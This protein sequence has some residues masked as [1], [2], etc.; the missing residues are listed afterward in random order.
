MSNQ[1]KKKNE[2]LPF[3][4]PSTSYIY[5]DAESSIGKSSSPTVASLIDDDASDLK[6]NTI[7]QSSSLSNQ[8][9]ETS[10]VEEEVDDET[11]DDEEL[12]DEEDAYVEQEA[13]TNDVPKLN[14]VSPVQ[15]SLFPN[16][17]SYLRFLHEG[18]TGNFEFIYYQSCAY[19]IFK[20]LSSIGDGKE[21]QMESSHRPKSG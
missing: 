5:Y 20:S 10:N 4:F 11:V 9:L 16:R 14:L 2:P 3:V 19:F 12:E 18:E 21:C 6:D 15:K 8:D 13:S 1:F 17:G 7:S